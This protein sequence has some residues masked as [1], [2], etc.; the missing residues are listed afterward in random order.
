MAF[1]R[2][3]SRGLLVTIGLIA[4]TVVVRAQSLTWPATDADVG[5]YLLVARSLQHGV[6]PYID[7]W[8]YKPPGA[9]ALYALAMWLTPTPG[10]ALALLGDVAVAAS[11]L[12]VRRIA[13]LIDPGRGAAIGTVAATL[14]IFCSIENE[15][16]AGDVELFIVPLT[17][18]AIALLV[19]LDRRE[20]AVW[21]YAAIGLLAAA[22]VQLKLTALPFALFAF[23]SIAWK[24]R[25]AAFAPLAAAAT[26]FVAPWVV[27]VAVYAARGQLAYLLDANVGATLRRLGS[28]SAA[29]ARFERCLEELRV[30]GP[31]IE[32][33]MLAFVLRLQRMRF[34]LAWFAVAVAT[35][36]VT[37][38]YDAR[39]F[40]SLLAPMSLLAALR[41]T[42]SAR[43]CGAPRS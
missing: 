35:I 18:G 34:M 22:A 6:L 2:A 26:A 19:P 25:R 27:E 37:N 39:H 43:G 17:A 30:L 41:S 7:V 20:A 32:L 4:L 16:L 21:R 12:L 31:P 13:V 1:D 36:V 10:L 11:A 3:G 24:E 8:E 5:S 28:R 14:L 38:E 42:A 23:V 29:P 15:G 9:F 33:A 40:C